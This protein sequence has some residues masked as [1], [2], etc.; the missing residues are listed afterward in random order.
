MPF[1][2]LVY[3]LFIPAAAQWAVD[4]HHEQSIQYRNRKA[5]AAI[6]R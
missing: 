5:S 4:G 1:L 6:G 2:V 3:A